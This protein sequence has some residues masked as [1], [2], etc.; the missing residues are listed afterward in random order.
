MYQQIN[1]LNLIDPVL[2]ELIS[3]QNKSNLNDGL[4]ARNNMNCKNEKRILDDDE[5]EEKKPT[6]NTVSGFVDCEIDIENIQEFKNDLTEGKFSGREA[7]IVIHRNHNKNIKK[8]NRSF[9]AC[10][11]VTTIVSSF[12]ESGENG[13]TDLAPGNK[14]YMDYGNPEI[15]ELGSNIS[16]PTENK[17]FKS[18]NKNSKSQKVPNSKS[19]MN[20]YPKE[21]RFF[22]EVQFNLDHD[23][24]QGFFRLNGKNVNRANEKP[25]VTR[26]NKY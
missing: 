14:D 2:R 10:D 4:L 9:E 11:G 23:L 20:I 24:D 17:Q 12:K 7:D 21:I 8:V 19:A 5:L 26:D 13:K 22:Q 6:L 15:Y 1:H 25:K 3:I 16:N 18:N